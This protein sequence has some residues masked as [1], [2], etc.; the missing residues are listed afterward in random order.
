MGKLESQGDLKRG[1]QGREMN[2]PPV[3]SKQMQLQEEWANSHWDAVRCGEG[4]SRLGRRIPGFGTDFASRSTLSFE[5]QFYHLSNGH[6]DIAL[7]T[8]H[9]C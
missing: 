5:S 2:D 8:S 1:K 4:R 7:I 9:S 3:C 6:N